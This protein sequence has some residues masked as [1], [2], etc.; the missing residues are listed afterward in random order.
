MVDGRLE[1]DL[2]GFERVVAGQEHVQGE[3]ASRRRERSQPGLG[4]AGIRTP[5]NNCLVSGKQKGPQKGKKKRKERGAN[6]GEVGVV[7]PGWCLFQHRS[8]LRGCPFIPTPTG[9][10]CIL[11]MKGALR[12]FRSDFHRGVRSGAKGTRDFR[13]HKMSSYSGEEIDLV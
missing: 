12:I 11:T 13:T 7:V 1:V 6:S 2:W 8:F 10:S 9:H 4:L 5:A 3:H